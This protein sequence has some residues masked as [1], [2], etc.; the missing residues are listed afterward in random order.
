MDIK[1]NIENS[2]K[3]INES[4]NNHIINQGDNNN[5]YAPVN[6]NYTII[7][8]TINNITYLEGGFRNLLWSIFGTTHD[9][10]HIFS[11]FV[12]HYD[13]K[14][15][16][17][18]IENIFWNKYIYATNHN[19]CSF[20]TLPEG[21]NIGDFIVFKG[22]IDNYKR[23]NKTNDV[24]IDEIQIIKI[25]KLDNNEKKFNIPI[26]GVSKED[27]E[28]FNNMPDEKLRDYYDI[29]KRRI[30]TYLEK[31]PDL[32][33]EMYESIL[34]TLFYQGDK[35]EDMISCRLQILDKN[36]NLLEISKWMSFVRYLIEDKG[37]VSPYKV[38]NI[39]LWAMKNSGRRIT[40][41]YNFISQLS[42]RNK[43]IDVSKN[44]INQYLM[45]SIIS[46]A[47]YIHEFKS[48][49]GEVLDEYD[50]NYDCEKLLIEQL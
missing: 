20:K 17:M 48:I 2:E 41:D 10:E 28:Y 31:Y 49:N 26:S 19:V 44:S 35:E 9:D 8:N 23:R 45:E 27:L 21:V 30:A 5:I 24:G 22:K 32:I 40:G 34:F 16:K 46:T 15:G 25:I 13:N 29:Q 38:Y 33:V 3:I 6:Y 50:E 12:N 1:N 39:L 43:I 7:Q 18:Y 36:I 4:N 14:T 42:L 47:D 11:G 37:I